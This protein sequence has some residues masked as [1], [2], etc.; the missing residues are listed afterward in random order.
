MESTKM[1]CDDHQDTMIRVKRL[2][3]D[4]Q[5]KQQHACIDIYIYTSAWVQ[6]DSLWYV[7]IILYYIYIIP[8]H[9]V[10]NLKRKKLSNKNIW[11]D[12]MLQIIYSYEPS[13]VS[14]SW[15]SECEPWF[16]HQLSPKS[17]ILASLGGDHATLEGMVTLC[18]S[19]FIPIRYQKGRLHQE[20]GFLSWLILS[21]YNQLGDVFSILY[22]ILLTIY[23]QLHP[24]S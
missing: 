11:L 9:H 16:F 19:M 22:P 18:S 15:T 6:C 3:T 1:W 17:Q 24:C 5:L 12:E 10:H 7:Y 4:E 13:K 2:L 8:T 14:I 20:F 23:N 21:I